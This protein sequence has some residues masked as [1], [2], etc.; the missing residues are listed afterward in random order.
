MSQAFGVDALIARIDLDANSAVT[1]TA[2]GISATNPLA[3]RRDSSAMGKFEPSPT[4]IAMASHEAR[5]AAITNGITIFDFDDRAARWAPMAAMADCAATIK[6][7][8]AKMTNA[9]LRWRA[10][11]KERRLVCMIVAYTTIMRRTCKISFGY[12]VFS[13]RSEFEVCAALL[14][15]CSALAHLPK[16]RPQSRQFSA[17]EA[18]DHTALCRAP[19]RQ[20]AQEDRLAFFRQ[21]YFAFA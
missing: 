3:G 16:Q 17:T 6:I 12:A 19:I 10:R 8:R 4:I 2:N 21:G 7:A 1:A 15:T 9:V 13:L 5:K 14:T 18:G 11:G 20:S